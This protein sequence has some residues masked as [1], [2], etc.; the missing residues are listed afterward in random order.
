MPANTTCFRYSANVTAD[1]GAGTN[2]ACFSY[3]A[4]SGNA[5]A[6]QAAPSGPRQMPTSSACFQYPHSCFS[7]QPHM[8]RSMPSMCF[9]YP[10]ATP[11]RSGSRD[12]APP[13][14]R[15]MPTTSTCFRY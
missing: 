2:S 9:S 13:G 7:Y 10:P 1:P 4:G 5:D 8:P 15:Q 6:P 12:A 14:L 3:P 11:A